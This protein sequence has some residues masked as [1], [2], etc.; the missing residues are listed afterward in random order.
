MAEQQAIVSQTILTRTTSV[1]PRAEQNG[2][3]S[4]VMVSSHTQYVA[5]LIKDLHHKVNC[6]EAGRISQCIDEWRKITSD[7]EILDMVNGYTIELIDGPPPH[8]NQS[9][10]DFSRSIK[11]LLHELELSKLITKSVIV[12]SC[13]EKGEVISPI[14]VCP[15][16]DDTHRMI[17]NLKVFTLM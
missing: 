3:N 16:K 10:Y 6:F 9:K 8:N 14:F 7:P 13:H 11:K 2:P 15:K 17:L 5:T 4:I 1:R 12:P